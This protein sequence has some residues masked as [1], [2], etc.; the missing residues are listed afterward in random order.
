MTYQ[1][2]PD[3]RHSDVRSMIE[4]RP[5]SLT[6]VRAFLASLGILLLGYMFLGRGFA[7]V[8]V[9][10]V[11]VGE[12]VLALGVVATA[13]ALLSARPVRPPNLVVWLLIAFMVLGAVRTVPYLGTYGVDALRDAVLWGYGAFALMLYVL[14]DRAVVLRSLRAYGWVVPIFAVWLPI[15]WTVAGWMSSAIDPSRPGEVIPIVY[16]KSGD[17]AV[18]MVGVIAFAVLGTRIFVPV[19]SFAARALLFIPVA[20]TGL[21]GATANRG[22]LVAGVTA[23]IVAIMCVPRWRV[24]APVVTGLV[25]AGLIFTIPSA[26]RDLANLPTPLPTASRAATETVGSTPPTSPRATPRVEP[27]APEGRQVGIGQLFENIASIFS[28]STDEGLSGTVAFRLAW[29]SEIVEYTAFGPYFWD[30]KGFGINLANADGFQPTADKSL[31][32]PHNSHLTVLARMGV[33]GFV[34]WWGLQGTFAVS[35]IRAIGA[36]RRRHQRVFSG[37]AAWLLVYWTAMMV[38]TSFDPYL[39]GPQGGIWFWSVF[40]IGL[41]LIRFARRPNR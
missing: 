33:P 32:A 24:W 16:F 14:V 10:P 7:H 22:A 38:D 1:R 8:G 35:L 19:R 34:L 21:V 28:G 31:R 5:F 17:M 18:H 30:G 15:S 23:L 12:V 4:R 37:T 11:Y 13:A 40:G 41:V 26:P 3:V 9:P 6:I 27:S 2:A 29:W 39:E 36:F 20:W 25:V